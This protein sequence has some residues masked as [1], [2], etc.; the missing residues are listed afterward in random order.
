M[1]NFTNKTPLFDLEHMK[2]I[3]FCRHGRLNRKRYWLM[4]LLTTL[5]FVLYVFALTASGFIQ[6]EPGQPVEMG[7]GLILLLVGY[8]FI[9]FISLMMNI[10]R[11]HD[12]GRSGHFLWLLLIP[13]VSLWPTIELLFLKGTEGS[14]KFGE[15]PLR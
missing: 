8:A 6:T 11:A 1:D 10:K 5:V 14:N 12:R 15:D 13:L 3:F 9:F 4:S 2:F 7:P